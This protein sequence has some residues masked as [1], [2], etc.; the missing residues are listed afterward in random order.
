MIMI[1]IMS[2]VLNLLEN[3]LIYYMA[4]SVKLNRTKSW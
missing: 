3:E 4:G 2:V 1:M